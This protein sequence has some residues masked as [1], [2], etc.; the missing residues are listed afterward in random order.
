MRVATLIITVFLSCIPFFA[1]AGSG[2][3]H[4]HGHA[5]AAVSQEQAVANATLLVQELVEQGHVENSW[6]PVQAE[7]SEQKVFE[8]APEWVVV[9]KNEAVA[10]TAEQTLYVFLTM[11]GEIIAANYTGE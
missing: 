9:F 10:D 7:S 4:G 2:H 3:D 8:G 6:L 5:H 11:A 1:F